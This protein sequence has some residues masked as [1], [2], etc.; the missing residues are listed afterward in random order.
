VEN[1][2]PPGR[3]ADRLDP[4]PLDELID[5]SWRQS[6]AVERVRTSAIDGALSPSERQF[7]PVIVRL[8]MA[9][10]LNIRQCRRLPE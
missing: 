10:R 6:E 7:S 2:S 3:I 1:P 8:T 4:A 9:V 5:Q